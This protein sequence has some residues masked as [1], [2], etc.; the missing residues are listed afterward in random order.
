MLKI[1]KNIMFS[2]AVISALNILG[3]TPMLMDKL[4]VRPSKTTVTYGE[5]STTNDTVKD[6]KNDSTTTADSQKQAWTIKQ[7]FVWGKNK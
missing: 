3:C 7:E 6:A 2:I 1:I 4:N 5:T